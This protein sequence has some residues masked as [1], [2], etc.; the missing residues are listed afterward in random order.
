LQV[1]S[2]AIHL[3]L[4]SFLAG[5]KPDAPLTV[6]SLAAA[7]RDD[8]RFALSRAQVVVTVESGERFLQLTDGIG[9]YAPGANETL[10][11]GSIEINPLEG[12]V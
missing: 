9:S 7:I 10:S 12:G 6:D 1:A 2:Q 3:A 8:T 11:K 4:D 5:R